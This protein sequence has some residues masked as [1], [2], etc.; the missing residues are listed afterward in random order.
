MAE[1]FVPDDDKCIVPDSEGSFV[2][3]ETTSVQRPG[4]TW[5]FARADG[6][7]VCERTPS[8]PL[9]HG[10]ERWEFERAPEQLEFQGSMP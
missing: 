4:V 6:T 9:Q 8:I 10:E 1:F 7:I 5:A 3:P 2:I